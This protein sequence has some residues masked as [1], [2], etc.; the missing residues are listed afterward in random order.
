MFG[1]YF[2]SLD[3]SG[4]RLDRKDRPELL[5]GSVDIQLPVDSDGGLGL[6]P[7]PEPVYIFAIEASSRTATNGA[8]A[9]VCSAIKDCIRYLQIFTVAV[10]GRYQMTICAGAFPVLRA[11]FGWVF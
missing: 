11:V 6:Q 2:C 10:V 9:Q 1:R 7:P 3:G 4:N 5:H 8:L